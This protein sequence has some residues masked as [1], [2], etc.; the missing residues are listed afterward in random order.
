[1]EIPMKAEN[2]LTKMKQFCLASSGDEQIWTNKNT[3]YFWNRGR[4]TADG[5]INGVVRKLAGTDVSG[6]RIWVVAGSLKINSQGKIE[7]FTGISKKTWRMLDTDTV[8][9]VPVPE[10]EEYNV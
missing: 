7:R 2:T 5:T 9:S 8:T 10:F 3:T 4:D 1:M 6:T